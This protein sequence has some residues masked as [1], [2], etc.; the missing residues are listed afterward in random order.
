[1]EEDS[2]CHGT[3]FSTYGEFIGHQTIDQ[4]GVELNSAKNDPHPQALTLVRTASANAASRRPGS[5]RG[6]SDE[7]PTNEEVAA[8]LGLGR[9][10]NCHAFAKRSRSTIPHRNRSNRIGFGY[11]RDM[12]MDERTKSPDE[13]NASI[14]TFEARGGPCLSKISCYA[15]RGVLKNSDFRT[16]WDR[17]PM[18]AQ[19]NR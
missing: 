10:K 5:Q 13:A 14:M 1:V 17:A 7:P 4:T 18:T 8:C 19:R 11:T 12:V 2:T 16:R 9:R 15:D 3:R 6:N